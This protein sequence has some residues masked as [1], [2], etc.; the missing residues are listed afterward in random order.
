MFIDNLNLEHTRMKKTNKFIKELC[1][2][3]MFQKRKSK[4]KINIVLLLQMFQINYY[5]TCLF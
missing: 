1:F 4:I 2:K 5:Y 3:P